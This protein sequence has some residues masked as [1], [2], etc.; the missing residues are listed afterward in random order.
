MEHFSSAATR[1]RARISEANGTK[2]RW[3]QTEHPRKL[4]EPKPP[5]RD[6]GTHVSVFLLA[7]DQSR[8]GKGL[9]H[10]SRAVDATAR[11]V[12]THSL[13]ST[14]IESTFFCC[15][16]SNDL[17]SSCAP[18]RLCKN[19]CSLTFTQCSQ[20]P[21]VACAYPLAHLQ[22]TGCPSPPC[23]RHEIGRKYRPLMATTM[24][25]LTP[26]SAC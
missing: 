10:C 17:S 6:D 5:S 9:I 8:L 1:K 3:F 20:N 26:E 16:A 2:R 22:M 18:R 14:R 25:T 24:M 12:R 7:G 15:S 11:A 13:H 23:A 21:D 4:F 19:A